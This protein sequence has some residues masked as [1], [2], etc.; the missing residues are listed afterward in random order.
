MFGLRRLSVLLFILQAV[1]VVHLWAQSSEVSGRIVDS[2]QA[3]VSGAK[4][5][6]KRVETGDTRNETSSAEGYFTFPLLLP[7][8]YDLKV[9]KD[10]FE[11]QNRTGI[12]VETAVISTVDVALPVG[13]VSQS[14]NVEASVPL[15]QT[16]TS[17]VSNVVENQTIVDMPLIDRRS[18]QLTRLSGFVVTNGAGA[19]VT[20]AIAGGR[21]NN[22]DYVVDGGTVQNLTLGVPTLMF[23]P[24]VESVQEFNVAIGNYSAEKTK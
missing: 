6:L 11:T 14:V 22:E 15:L 10:G 2:S 7:G 5:T 19:S 20:F 24:P 8:T 13:A 17:S 12:K 9:Q 21:G 18:A 1:A 4:V 16:E 23:D 3:A